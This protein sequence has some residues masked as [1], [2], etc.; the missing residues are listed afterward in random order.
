MGTVSEPRE[1]DRTQAVR[2]AVARCAHY[3]ELKLACPPAS[4]EDWAI[5]FLRLTDLVSEI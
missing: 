1:Y 4:D 3:P 5:N 2:Y